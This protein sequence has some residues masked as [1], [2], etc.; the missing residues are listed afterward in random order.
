MTKYDAFG[1]ELRR[2]GSAV[3]RFGY[4]GTSW[5]RHNSGLYESRTRLYLPG[6]GRYQQVD[7]LRAML[8]TGRLGKYASEPYD[9]Y[10]FGKPYGPGTFV[11]SGQWYSVASAATHVDPFGLKW[12]GVDAPE[13]PKTLTEEHRR[14]GRK[15]PAWTEPIS[16]WDDNRPDF[17]CVEC[18]PPCEDCLILTVEGDLIVQINSWCLE[19][20][21]AEYR[22][23]EER[24]IKI[25][26]RYHAEMEYAIFK[27][28]KYH[29]CYPSKTCEEWVKNL[30]E[31]VKKIRAKAYADQV[32]EGLT[33]DPA[34]K[35]GTPSISPSGEPAPKDDVE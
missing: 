5:M 32:V 22:R 7:P 25:W 18:S 6:E 23:H 15:R 2:S 24:R 33:G 30:K 13:R 4:Q 3:T 29:A 21:P 11:A 14:G 8:A 16:G 10:L 31:L 19:N 9:Y 20:L 34:R 17:K 1:E 12:L 35:P 28:K 26:K 27:A